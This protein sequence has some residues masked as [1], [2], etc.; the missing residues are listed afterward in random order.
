M[1]YTKK[2]STALFAV[3][4]RFLRSSAKGGQGIFQIVGLCPCGD[5]FKLHR[6][7]ARYLLIKCSL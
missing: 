7:E 2:Y 4:H 1:E 6:S 3:K 5:Y